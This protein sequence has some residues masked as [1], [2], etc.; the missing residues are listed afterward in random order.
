MYLILALLAIALASGWIAQLIVGRSHGRTDWT[1]ALI[2]GFIGSFVGGLL[3]SLIAGDG[4]D[5]RP[6]GLI[7]SIV[8][9]VIVTAVWGLIRGRQAA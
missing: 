3:A 9:A 4:F 7:G 8:G 2:A 1:Q 5:F 6:S